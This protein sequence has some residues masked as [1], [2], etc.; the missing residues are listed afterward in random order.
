MLCFALLF[1]DLRCSMACSSG[2]ASN[3]V[4]PVGVSVW[5]LLFAKRFAVN[6]AKAAVHEDLIQKQLDMSK[7]TYVA[8]LGALGAVFATITTVA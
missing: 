1:F 4:R 2:T 6:D 3:V 5:D 7:S 8:L